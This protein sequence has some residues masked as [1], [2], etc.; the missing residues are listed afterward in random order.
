METEALLSQ[1]QHEATA[2][3][4]E[5]AR[6]KDA[7]SASIFATENATATIQ[8]PPSIELSALNEP[9]STTAAASRREG[10]DLASSSCNQPKEFNSYIVISIIQVTL[11]LFPLGLCALW[12]SVMSLK[13]LRRGNF[14]QA[15]QYAD[16]ARKLNIFGIIASVA[17]YGITAA[18]VTA[19]MAF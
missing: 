17:I 12:H 10:E 11:C 19:V 6:E 15:A 1:E 5:E 9:S 8:L 7:T 18:V 13:H 4:E 16:R 3:G 14:S 2:A